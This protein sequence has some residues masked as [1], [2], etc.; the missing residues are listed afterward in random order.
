[1]SDK[2][3]IHRHLD[4]AVRLCAKMF[5]ALIVTGARQV[6]KTTLL[7][8]VNPRTPYITMD[9]P[10]QF[11]AAADDPGNFFKVNP[12]PL[13]VDEIQYTPNLFPYIKM[14]ADNSGKKGLFFLSGSQQFH[15]MK[16]VSE[17]LAGRIGILNLLGLS[18]REIQ[19]AD[20]RKPFLPSAEY[21]EARKRTAVPLTHKEIWTAIHQGSLPEMQRSGMNWEIFYAAYVKSYLERDV[22]ELTKIGDEL[23]FLKFMS[24]AASNTGN[25]LNYASIAHDIGVSLPTVERWISILSASNIIY[26][27]PPYHN[28][29]RK[30]ALKT[31]KLYFLDTGLAAYLT[32]WNNPE[33]LE[34]GASAGAFFETWVIAEIIKS[35]ANAGKEPPLYFYR[36]KEQ[37]EIDLLI[38]EN[39]VL[40]PLEIKK[41]ATPKKDDIKAFRILEDIPEITRGPG[42]LICLYDR[43]TPLGEK[44]RVIPLE[45]I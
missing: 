29:I 17:S 36:D 10:V 34:H 44:D 2:V 45:Y 8:K 4:N 43:I 21:L 9:D 3:Y 22:R 14:L 19:G 20:F 12:P 38:H 24:A 41:R 35:Y 15:L 42:G 28:N 32:R 37:N 30:R 5:P 13:V 16:N 40:Y 39:G 23:T 7:R 1:M 31:P 18:R 27:L 25:L 11:H 26:L 6:G 33:V